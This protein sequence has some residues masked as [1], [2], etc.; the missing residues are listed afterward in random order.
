EALDNTYE[1]I[2][3]IVSKITTTYTTVTSSP[4][5]V[6]NNTDKD[7]PNNGSTTSLA[8]ISSSSNVVI[9]PSLSTKAIT[10]ST[11][12]QF[13]TGLPDELALKYQ[14]LECLVSILRSLVAWCG[15]KPSSENVEDEKEES[16]RKSEE[17]VEFVSPQPVFTNKSSPSSS[18]MSVSGSMHNVSTDAKVAKPLDDPEEFGNLKHRKQ[19]LQDGIKMFNFKPKKGINSLVSAGFIKSE[20]PSEIAKFLLTTEGLSKAMIGEYL[21]EGDADNIAT[22]HAF[23]DLMDFKNMNF[24]EALRTFLQSFR[25]PGEAQKIDRFMLK[26]AERYVDGNPSQFANADTAYVLAYSVIML[27]TDLHNPQIKR[28]MTKDEFI[29][30]N[31]GINDNSDLPEEFL[32]AI[33]DEIQNNEIKMKDEHDAALMQQ[34]LP[35]PGRIG[36]SNIGSV[37]VNAGRD[38]KKAA[39]H[40][41]VLKEMA[42]KTETLFKSMLR[43]QRRGIYTANTTFYSASHFEHVR[44]MFE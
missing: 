36:I 27:N 31:R 3:N 38:Y 23:V 1:R 18:T 29:R 24:V 20:E 21:G 33:Y 11:S 5:S 39:A 15:N 26:F 19:A 8:S 43:A 41:A 35:S 14:G 2:V 28:R 9:P 32:T 17:T 42:N 40:Q 37:I 4:N 44:P 6:V 13:H 10:V 30:N 34:N 22:M 25:L 16:P 7:S 12:S